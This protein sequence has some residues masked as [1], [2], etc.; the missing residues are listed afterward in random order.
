MKRCKINQRKQIKS[1]EHYVVA[2]L[3]RLW[4]E[5]SIATQWITWTT[6]D[7]DHG[8]HNGRRLNMTVGTRLT[9][10]TKM[11]VGTITIVGLELIVG[12]IMIPG[13]KNY[14]QDELRSRD[15]S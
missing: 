5:K 8:K 15:Q 2:I 1:Q 9:I 10:E 14:L 6:L 3:K 12:P 13:P 4:D 11:I 7:S